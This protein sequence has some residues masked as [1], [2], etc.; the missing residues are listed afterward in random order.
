MQLTR[1][2]IGDLRAI[3]QLD[4]NLVDA[5]GRP[6]RRLVLLGANGAG[7]TTILDAIAHAF[8]VLTPEAGF[9]AKSLGAG[10]VSDARTAQPGP[11]SAARRGSITLE[12]ELS[13][14]ERRAIRPYFQDAPARGTLGFLVAGEAIDNLLLSGHAFV[15]DGKPT[16]REAASA[17]LLEGYPPCVL[18]PADR[19]V[20]E[21][22]EEL[23]LKQLTGFDPRRDCLAR[24]RDRFAPLAARLALA[25]S[26]GKRND[27]HGTVARMWKVLDK[28]MKE[29]PRPVDVDGLT[30]RFENGDGSIVPLTALSD[31]Q[32]AILLIFGELAL[33]DP[34]EGVVLIDEVEQHLHPKWQR[35]ILYALT[36]LLPN[37][38]F[39]LTTQSPYLAACAPDD[40][41][42]VGDW[43]R[44]GE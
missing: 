11:E 31:G 43:D 42:K 44:D 24:R 19:G 13:N 14:E 8:Q 30:L 34:K 23:Q 41:L 9:G 39:I 33:R 16:F 40:M 27:P 37:A 29:M 3:K 2:T 35:E 12:A 28:H 17:A 6:R 1:L 20:L 22:S 4:V 5:G 7:K 18:L 25:F 38:Q 10:D 15:S 21:E 26:G 36:S 32:R